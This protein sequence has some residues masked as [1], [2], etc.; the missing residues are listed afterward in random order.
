MSL[1]IQKSL[2][3]KEVLSPLESALLLH[4]LERILIALQ[5]ITGASASCE[6][7]S[8]VFIF[9]VLIKVFKIG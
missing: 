5:N 6:A 9:E 8:T 2:P 1:I 3:L 7:F 4:L